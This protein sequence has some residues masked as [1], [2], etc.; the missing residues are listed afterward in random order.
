[1]SETQLAVI[2]AAKSTED[3]HESIPTQLAEAR[4]MAEHE[5]WDVVA[6]YDDEGFSA[7]SGDRGPGLAAAKRRAVEAAKS[8]GRPCMLIA[9]AHDRFA[10]GAGDAPGAPQHLVELWIEMRR[11]D[12]QL[13]TVEDDFDMRDVQSVAAIGQRA[14]MDSRRKSKSVKKG[15]ARRRAK[16][17]HNGRS[18]YGYSYVAGAWETLE[19]EAV[20]VRRIF[21]EWVGGTSQQSICRRLNAEGV[22]TQRGGLWRQ[23]SI[24]KVLRN[25][26]YLGLGEDGEPC[27]CGHGALV[28]AATFE[29]AQ[30]L[31]FKRERHRLGGPGRRPTGGHLF[32]N[33]FL[34]CGVCGEA[35]GP[36]T[37][38]RRGY[39]RYICLGQKH[40]G[41]ESC[42]MRSIARERLES[43]VVEHFLRTRVDVEDMRTKYA[44]SIERQIAE[45]VARR[46]EAQRS[47][48]RAVERLRRVKAD[49]VDGRLEAVDWRE[50]REELEAERVAAAGEAQQLAEREAELRAAV[51][52]RD[53]EEE[54]LRFLAELRA[55]I[56][57]PV[58]DAESLDALRAGFRR[59]YASFTVY[60]AAHPMA[61]A[62]GGE[63]GRTSLVVVPTGHDG[64]FGVALRGGLRERLALSMPTR[65]ADQTNSYAEGFATKSS[66][67][68]SRPRTRSSSPAVPVRMISGSVGSSREAS[69]SAARTR[70]TTSSP[71]P[72]G[73]PRS[74][75]ARSGRWYSSI[76]IA[77]RTQS[78]TSRS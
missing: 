31:G 2:Y 53:A 25:A 5:G 52:P 54:V 13:R 59:V 40:R 66:A 29:A 14:M 30:A 69:P 11:H 74:M 65:L 71:E 9:Q 50:L 23:G 22:P 4:E 72:S 20:V 68:S 36:R 46:A 26:S 48:M 32:L 58:R 47:E 33:G 3:K 73:S 70:R 76:R 63:A 51:D 37:D 41:P 45:A 21:A 6:E 34:R 35:M 27:Q 44:E 7:Y 61:L 60:P 77:S 67:P 8:T 24:S 75:T 78:A 38:V 18:V 39:E 16:G 1:M 17:M 49:Y 62:F 56:T 10:R 12:V 55:G 42:S 57:A 15:M 28:D 64:L 43:G 19:A